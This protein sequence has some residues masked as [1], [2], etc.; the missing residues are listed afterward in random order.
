MS[1]DDAGQDAKATA[2][3]HVLYLEIDEEVASIID[4][5]RQLAAKQV[6]LVIPAGSALLAS[7]VNLKLLAR[8]LTKL[9]K[10][11]SIV[12]KDKKGKRMAVALGI[13]VLTDIKKAESKKARAPK[14][15]RKKGPEEFGELGIAE[16][17]KKQRLKDKMRGIDS[18]K[19]PSP[20]DLEVIRKEAFPHLP[21]NRKLLFI[22]VLV[23]LMLVGTVFALV[24]PNT[25]IILEPKADTMEYLTNVTLADAKLNYAE[26]REF[27]TNV[28]P[29]YELEAKGTKRHTYKTT[30]VANVGANA[31]G[32]VIV[33]NDTAISW[34]LVATTRLRSEG[35][36]IFRLQKGA[37]VAPRSRG[38]VPVV[39]DP[40]DELGR[41]VGDRGNI[42]P[43]K[44]TIPGLRESNQQVVYAISDTAM[45]GGVSEAAQIASEDDIKAAK[46]DIVNRLVTELSEILKQQA[47][48]KS[49][50]LGVQLAY[51]NLTEAGQVEVVETGI[52][53][54]LKI[55]DSATELTAYATVILRG[56]A[57]EQ[58]RFYEILRRGLT[59]R[60]HPNMRLRTID[61]DNI[62]Y[63]LLDKNDVLKKIKL[64]TN[65]RGVVEFDILD[66][67]AQKIKENLAGRSLTEAKEYLQVQDFVAQAQF[68]MWPF[69]LKKIPS[70]QENI[71]IVIK[72]E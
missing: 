72:A 30:G 25:T 4:R 36:I 15:A 54:E 45:S 59:S 1:P 13:P 55:N 11:L 39:A 35:G 7:A 6:A 60:I 5:V 57:F 41:V 43:G 56:I 40:V 31:A 42:G 2:T 50:D 21:P 66:H 33:V 14:S 47:I 52:E 71:R 70:V 27:N 37:V 53:G 20:E 10:E 67:Y 8:Q 3:P 48:A 28:V 65:V 68:Q 58:D 44:F 38:R 23:T 62:S 63:K 29:S 51:L 34:P 49:T 19:E 69:W 16:V 64:E 22:F 24:V 12:T 26:I 18:G 46:A 17:V 9:G 61:F 32:T